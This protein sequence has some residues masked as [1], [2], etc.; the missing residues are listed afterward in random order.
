MA[1]GGIE[2][3]KAVADIEDRMY[4]AA[5]KEVV[6]R[7][8]IFVTSL[9]RAG[10]TLLLD[11]IA[12][13]PGSAV[14]TYRNMPF[15]LCPLLWRDISKS[16]RKAGVARARAHGDGMEVGF[17]SPEAFEEVVW[18][19]FWPRKYRD[20]R[21]EL[22]YA[23]DRDPEFEDFF[24]RH[25]RK[26]VFAHSHGGVRRYVSK[27]NANIARIPLLRRLFP[28]ARILVP[29]RDPF[30]QAASLLNQ[31]RRFT[32]AH[33]EDPFAKYYMESIGHLEFGAAFTPIAFA[34]RPATEAAHELPFWITYWTAAFTH[35]LAQV[36]D[37]D[38]NVYFVDFGRLCAAP[39]RSL[40][41][42][43]EVLGDADLLIQQA[44]R[45]HAAV[46]YTPP[47]VL[48]SSPLGENAYALYV[49]L[50]ARAVN[51]TG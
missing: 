11:A 10:T 13:L 50:Q 41:A 42:V 35:L 15:I 28:D 22:W 18:R 12:A 9:P 5:L 32:Q 26:L 1:F 24:R 49:D 44:A 48:R 33:A 29:F 37:A 3:Q 46:S 31:H 43:G 27:N 14:H 8:P 25:M 51:R 4:A 36:Q 30:D 45:F 39:E 16:F 20:D 19:A 6:P 2:L 23:D 38:P 40:R 7:P 47:E 17:D 21:I 34:N